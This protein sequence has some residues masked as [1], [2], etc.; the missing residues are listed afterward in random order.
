MSLISYLSLDTGSHTMLTHIS[1]HSIEPQ[2]CFYWS[3]SLSESVFSVVLFCRRRYWYVCWFYKIHCGIYAL[4]RINALLKMSTVCRVKYVAVWQVDSP[5]ELGTLQRC[6]HGGWSSVHCWLSCVV[7][8]V[9]DGVF[10]RRPT[11]AR[12][13]STTER[14]QPLFHHFLWVPSVDWHMIRYQMLY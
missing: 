11:D 1:P 5:E 6:V 3:Y 14:A 7:A 4:I 8:R 12:D 10:T 13:W 9:Q 2:C